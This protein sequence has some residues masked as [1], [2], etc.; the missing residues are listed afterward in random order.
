MSISVLPSLSP[1]G[2]TSIAAK[3]FET[4]DAIAN[5][6]TEIDY[7]IN[8]TRAK[9]HDWDY[10]REEMKQIVSICKDAGLISKVH[11]RELLP[12]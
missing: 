2:Q 11:I 1:L 8:L 3:E 7:V 10:I 12:H 9:A 6:A 4:Q 5:G